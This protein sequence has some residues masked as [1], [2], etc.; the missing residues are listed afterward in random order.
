MKYLVNT[1]LVLEIYINTDFHSRYI[2]TFMV[3][4]LGE[5]ILKKHF[6]MNIKNE[7]SVWW[8]GMM[9]KTLFKQGSYNLNLLG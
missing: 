7:K 3:I 8:D 2:Q 4:G 9:V 1:I 5:G 6:Q